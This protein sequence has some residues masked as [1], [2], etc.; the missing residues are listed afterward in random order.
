[1]LVYWKQLDQGDEGTAAEFL[2]DAKEVLLIGPGVSRGKRVK[3]Q[4]NGSV[5]RR[6]KEWKNC[7]QE[8]ESRCGGFKRVCVRVCEVSERQQWPH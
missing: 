4:L 3:N 7:C 5:I 2:E 1:M 6:D 8:E